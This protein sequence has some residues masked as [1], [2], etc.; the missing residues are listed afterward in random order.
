MGFIQNWYKHTPI[1]IFWAGHEAVLLFFILSGFVLTIPFLKNNY[2][3][4]KGYLVKRFF[5]IYLASVTSIFLAVIL[6]KILDNNLTNVTSDWI[7][8]LWN[9]DFTIQDVINHLVLIGH[10]PTNLNPVLWSLV[11]E[12]RISVIFPIIVY[13]V[14]RLKW[15][16]VL[17][18]ALSLSTI[19]SV[20]LRILSDESTGNLLLTAH[21][22]GMFIVGSLSQNIMEL[23][24][25]K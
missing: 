24:Y 14:L 11:H 5:R 19:S 23:L 17:I 18:L 6:I 10:Y 9:R 25:T 13:F 15:K 12:M 8:T 1:H 7:N 20:I 4:Y 22:S 16:Q 21:Y 3:S 2:F